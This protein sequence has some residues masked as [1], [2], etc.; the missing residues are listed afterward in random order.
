MGAVLQ[1]VQLLLGSPRD[2]AHQQAIL[3]RGYGMIK[4]SMGVEAP[5]DD[6]DTQKNG[7]GVKGYQPNDSSPKDKA[8]LTL[9][10]GYNDGD[11]RNKYVDGEDG[12][13]IIEGDSQAQP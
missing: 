13:T 12:A 2:G 10:D 6:F 1:E 8:P 11:G 7:D 9:R 5:K 4:D 3:T